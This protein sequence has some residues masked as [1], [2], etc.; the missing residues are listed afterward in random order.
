MPFEAFKARVKIVEDEEVVKKWMEDQ[1]WKTEYI[2]LNVP[3][4]L[5]LPNGM[6]AVEKHFRE[7]HM[8]NIIKPVESH[9]LSGAAAR[10][11]ALPRPGAPG[12]QRLGGAA[13]FSAC[14]SPPTLSQQFAGHGL[15]FFKVNRTVTHVSVARPH[16]LDL[17]ADA[18]FGRRQA[19][20]RITS[21]RIP[22]A[23]RRKLIEALAPAPAAAP[24][25]GETAAQ[26]ARRA[27][28]RPPR[29]TALKPTPEQTALVMAICT[30]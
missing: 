26:S 7:T 3:E 30:G 27:D 22:N 15:Q 29:R 6:E 21:M 28:P 23:H 14:R 20:R 11:I 12:A 19:H 2:C 10:A 18:C 9:T 24:A 1:S 8:G 4:A 13:A 25:P 17:A 5:R 16:Y